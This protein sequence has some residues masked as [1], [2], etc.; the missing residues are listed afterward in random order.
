M[1]LVR[2]SKAEDAILIGT[3]NNQLILHLDI[4]PQEHSVCLNVIATSIP[5]GEVEVSTDLTEKQQ[6]GQVLTGKRL[7][8]QLP[9]PLPSVER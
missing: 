8:E 4:A 7:L 5:P 1:A 6:I 9:L 3:N 2:L